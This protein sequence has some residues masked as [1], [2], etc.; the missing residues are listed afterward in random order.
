MFTFLFGLILY[1]SE[2]SHNM[3]V[4]TLVECCCCGV[5]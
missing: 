5:R 4:K 1:F 2:L 3:T